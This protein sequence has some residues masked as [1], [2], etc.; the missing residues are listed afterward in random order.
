MIKQLQEVALEHQI[1]LTQM[2]VLKKPQSSMVTPKVACKILLTM[3]ACS[4]KTGLQAT[5]IGLFLETMLLFKFTQQWVQNLTTLM[6][7]LSLVLLAL[8]ESSMS[9]KITF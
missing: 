2:V 8:R 4:I 5:V 1:V 9:L 3:S 6:H 7:M